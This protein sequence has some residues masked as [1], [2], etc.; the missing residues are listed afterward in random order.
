M[1]LRRVV[2][3]KLW[4]VFTVV[5][6]GLAIVPLLSILFD[7]ASKGISVINLDFFTQLPPLANASGGGMGNAIQGTLLLVALS[8]AI[9]L[10][11]GLFSGVYISEYGVTN[12]YGS[13]VRF[14]GD[15]L[16]G[17]P[18][19]VT[20]VLAYTLIVLTF[21]SFSVLAG[22]VA[23]GTMMIP[24]VSNTT[25]EA[26]KSVPNSIRE[27]SI[28]LGIRKWRTSLLIMANA[29]KAIAT[30]SL[31][32]IARITGETAPLILTAGISTLWFSGFNQPVGSLTYYIYYFGTSPYQN[33]Q[34]MAWGAALILIA[35]VLGI[36]AAVR[37]ITRGKKAYA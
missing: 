10:P 37:L 9:G 7:I 26:L 2:S 23:L 29:K 32:A 17:I 21:Q 31:L 14:L 6:L 15:V 34:N 19:I 25:A 30:A 18:S 11:I 12:R 3:D 28:A 20:G 27:A 33:W 22:G 16:A 1:K 5:A 13:A 35:I 36:N 8:S 4:T 24:I